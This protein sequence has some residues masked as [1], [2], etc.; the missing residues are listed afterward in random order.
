MYT[1]HYESNYC[2]ASI[3]STA[4]QTGSAWSRSTTL[5]ETEVG[6]IRVLQ[7]T[8]PFFDPSKAVKPPPA[9]SGWVE[10]SVSFLGFRGLA[11]FAN[12]NLAPVWSE[13]EQTTSVTDAFL[14]SP[15][16]SIPKHLRIPRPPTAPGATLKSPSIPP[17]VAPS[18]R[19]LP[20][21]ASSTP[22]ADA[23]NAWFTLPR[24]GV[25]L[26]Q[27]RARRAA[28]SHHPVAKLRDP[29]SLRIY[30]FAVCASVPALLVYFV[31]WAPEGEK[32]DIAVVSTV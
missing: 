5:E 20:S 4:V 8:R 19:S 10:V 25:G 22:A 24:F 2:E 18:A 9:L 14:Q 11:P 17:S 1:G 30:G 3:R 16:A 23:S 12:P 6:Q 26:P 31:W 28:A 29:V 13:L 15:P 21:A 7:I 27:F 32:S